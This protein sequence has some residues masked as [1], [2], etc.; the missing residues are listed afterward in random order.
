MVADRIAT[1]WCFSG[2]QSSPQ[3]PLTPPLHPDRGGRWAADLS[4]RDKQNP[5]IPRM[6]LARLC[7]MT[8]SINIAGGAK[9]SLQFFFENVAGMAQCFLLQ[10]RGENENSKYSGSHWTW[11]YFRIYICNFPHTCALGNDTVA[12]RPYGLFTS[13]ICQ[14]FSLWIPFYKLG[15]IMKA[16]WYPCKRP[17]NLLQ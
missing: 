13:E 1:P 11:M 17:I 5:L 10:F 6:L 2:W 4:E 12:L 9:L 15:L 14:Y 7:P 16:V 8:S 3:Q